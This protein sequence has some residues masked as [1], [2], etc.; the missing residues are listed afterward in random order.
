MKRGRAAN[1]AGRAGQVYPAWGMRRNQMTDQAEA[2]G[3][4]S[5]S[6]AFIAN[7]HATP[8]IYAKMYA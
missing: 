1:F 6:D 2:T 4:Y 3:V 5:A 7:A 8:E